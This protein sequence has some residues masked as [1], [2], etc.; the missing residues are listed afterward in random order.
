MGL[1][2][3]DD[4][5]MQRLER[6]LKEA[7][8]QRKDEQDDMATKKSYKDM[9]VDE[10][11]TVLK[12]ELTYPLFKDEHDD[13]RKRF[14]EITNKRSS[15]K[16]S[17]KRNLLEEPFDELLEDLK[18][19]EDDTKCEDKRTD[20]E[21]LKPYCQSHK[22]KLKGLCDKTCGYC[23][24]C[25]NQAGDD[26]C[27][28]RQ[29]LCNSD[30]YRKQLKVYCTQACG[31]CKVPS[32]PKCSLT[33]YKCCWDKETPKLN[34]R[35]SNCPACRDQYKYV[36]KTFK[37]DCDSAE[38]PGEFMRFNCPQSCNLCSGTACKDDSKKAFYCPFWKKDLKWCESKKEEMRHFCPKTCGYC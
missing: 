24:V 9:S 28:L 25:E 8:T 5:E 23:I 33:K 15:W 3:Y 11:V 22:E 2:E 6:D 38:M 37:P 35:G 19:D 29:D 14:H 27:K 30:K 16:K 1:E 36:C 26:F 18:H 34:S 21:G 10:L 17:A 12:Q 7:H 32:P 4:L 20:C 13:F 31:Y